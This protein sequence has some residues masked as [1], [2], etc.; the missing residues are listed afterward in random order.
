MKISKGKLFFTI[1]LSLIIVY[2]S[3]YTLVLSCVVWTSIKYKDFYLLLNCISAICLVY[4]VLLSLVV[5]QI[6]L[7]GGLGEWRLYNDKRASLSS[8][9]LGLSLPTGAWKSNLTTILR[10]LQLNLKVGKI[11]KISK[12]YSN[13]DIFDFYVQFGQTPLHFGQKMDM[14]KSCTFK[15]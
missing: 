10:Y 7:P 6:Y 2:F 13:L 15:L 12:C 5:T 9:W 3:Y 4:L 8:T 1:E 11:F 14:F